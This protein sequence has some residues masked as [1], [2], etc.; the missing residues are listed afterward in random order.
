MFSTHPKKNVL[1]CIHVVCKCFQFGSVKSQMRRK[2]CGKRKNCLCAISPFPTVFKRLVQQTHKNQGLSGKRIQNLDSVL[3]LYHTISTFKRPRKRQLLKTL[4][5]K[6][7]IVLT[8]QSCLRT[9]WTKM[10]LEKMRNAG[11]HRCDFLT[12]S[13]TA[14]KLW[15][16]EKMQV[17]IT[18]MTLISWRMTTLCNIVA[19]GEN[20]GSQHF[21]LFPHVF[22]IQT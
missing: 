13:K 3:T 12:Q 11:K 21:L 1:N 14:L 4:P 5:E 18:I 7:K 20:A 6:N 15:E 22:S 2:H 17:T 10:A 9:I 8:A 19:K 16:K